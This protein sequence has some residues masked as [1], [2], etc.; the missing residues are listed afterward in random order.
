MLEFLYATLP[1][2]ILLRILIN[3]RISNL[4]GKF[5]DSSLSKVLIKPFVRKNGIDLSYFYSSNF[6]C[7]NDC[8]SRKIKPG[9]RNFDRDPQALCSPCDGLL[10]AYEISEG[11]VVPVK[12]KDYDI[13]RLL[14]SRKLAARYDGGLCLVFRLCVDH[15]HRYCY[16]DDGI[17]GENHFIA[18]KLHTV[19]PIALYNVPVFAENSREYT[20]IKTK[21]FGKI[22]QMEVGAMLVGK[23]NNYHGRYE[24][25]RGVEKGCFLYGG[26]T[27]I[28]LLRKDKAVLDDKIFAA[29]R[30]GEETPVKMGEKIGMSTGRTRE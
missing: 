30:A 13:A 22:V 25:V 14:H 15:Y 16:I 20:V 21:N 17:K 7:F 12:G 6:E 11:L 1:G 27:V 5:L 26:S 28:L 18:G 4:C 3:P 29:T 19:R 24:F 8:F 2:R 10:S 23:I 9:Y